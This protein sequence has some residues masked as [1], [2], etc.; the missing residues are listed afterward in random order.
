MSIHLIIN[1]AEQQAIINALAFYNDYHAGL[2]KDQA[3]EAYEQWQY[4][5]NED[6]RSQG[7]DGPVDKL[8]TKVA[9]IN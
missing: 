3:Y 2:L 6:N 8:A 5:F 1:G 9:T 4:A 7:A